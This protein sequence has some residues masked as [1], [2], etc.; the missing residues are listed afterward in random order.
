MTYLNSSRRGAPLVSLSLSGALS[1]G[2]LKVIEYLATLKYPTPPTHD[3]PIGT[4]S[5]LPARARWADLQML[6]I[7]RTMVDTGRYLFNRELHYARPMLQET[8]QWIMLLK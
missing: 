2:A 5:C 1:D 8:Y 6:N 4:L 7:Q 3:N